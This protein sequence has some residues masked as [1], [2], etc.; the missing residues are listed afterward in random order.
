[1]D[2]GLTHVLPVLRIAYLSKTL[3][4]SP[5][6]ARRLAAQQILSGGAPQRIANTERLGKVEPQNTARH[7]FSCN[8]TN[9]V[10][11]MGQACGMRTHASAGERAEDNVERYLNDDEPSGN[12]AGLTTVK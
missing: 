7:L 5:R 9:H 3:S 12:W 8:R 4:I 1:M 11:Q 6:S 2:I 10:A